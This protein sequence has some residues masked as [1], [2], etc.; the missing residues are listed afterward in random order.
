MQHHKKIS[1]K[2]TLL[3]IIIIAIA[4]VVAF[5]FYFLLSQYNYLSRVVANS[6]EESL[7]LA[8]KNYREYRFKLFADTQDGFSMEVSDLK[9]HKSEEKVTMDEALHKLNSTII[10][11][12]PFEINKLDSIYSSILSEKQI[13][14]D[15]AIN[16]YKHNSDSILETTIRQNIQPKYS[17][18][19]IKQELDI[20]RDVEILFTNPTTLILRKMSLLLILSSIILIIVVISLIYQF[21]IIYKQKKSNKSVKILPIV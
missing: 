21:R 5:Q 12:T 8:V 16:I 2:N 17:F 14:S 19:T 6:Y 4:L 20:V 9:T 7:V 15:Y 10:S 13:L 3:S 18:H 11:L 1:E